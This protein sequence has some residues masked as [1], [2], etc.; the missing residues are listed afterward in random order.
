MI[1]LTLILALGFAIVAVIFALQNTAL[2]TVTFFGTNVDGSLALFILLSVAVGV[3]IGV[4]VMIPGSIK[5]SFE[6]RSHRK[7]INTLEK[8]LDEHK[9][10]LTEV[11]QPTEVEPPVEPQG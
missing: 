6:L 3:L 8:T 9:S 4:L 2:V 11:E 1:I 7:Q 10:L 5:H